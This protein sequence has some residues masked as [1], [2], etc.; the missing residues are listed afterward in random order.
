MTAAEFTD[1]DRRADREGRTARHDQPLG[2]RADAAPA[3]SRVPR[4]G[5]APGDLARLD[6]DQRAA[7]RD[8]LEFCR[9]LAQAQGLCQPAARRAAQSRAARRCAAAGDQHAVKVRA[10]DN[11]ERAGVRTTIVS[12]V[13]KG[14]NDRPDRRL[15][16]P[17]L[18][19]RL[20]PV[21]DVPAGGVHRLR[22]RAFRAARSAER[23]HDPRHRPR[24]RGA[25]RRTA[26]RRAISCRCRARTRAASA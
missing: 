23:H 19:A 7:H 11:L 5:G 18:R 26:R 20:H 6:L 21:A 2:R 13:A 25:D 16:P 10:L 15:R 14:V 4:P 12:T 17:A 22:R 9:E 3:V 24:R 8:R 1:I